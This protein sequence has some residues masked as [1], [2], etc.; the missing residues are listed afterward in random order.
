MGPLLKQNGYCGYINLNTIVNE[1]GIWPLEFTCRFGYPGYA[2]LDPLQRTPWADLFRSMLDRRATHFEVEP[3][4]C[5]GIVITTPPYPY[6]REDVAE[7]KGFPIMFKGGLSADER[8]NLHYGEVGLI[9]DVLVTSGASGYTLVVTGRGDT[10]AAAR[11]A[12]NALADK[13]VVS[14]ARYRRDIGKKLIE[15]D[16]AK[17]RAWGLID[18]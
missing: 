9:E 6:S 18:I 17:V 3:G 10:I 2:I 11:D 14:N 4:F 8:A 1:K 13:V 5:V 7:P 15:G 16:F 12:A